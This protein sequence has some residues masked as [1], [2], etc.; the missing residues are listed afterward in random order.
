MSRKSFFFK[1]S[2]MKKIILLTVLLF[3]WFAH[4]QKDFSHYRLVYPIGEDPN[5]RWISSYRPEEK[6]LFEANPNVR[7]SFYNNIIKRFINEVQ[8]AEGNPLKG[9]LKHPQAYYIAV[10]PQFRMYNDNS[11]PVKMPSYRV[12]FGTQHL[13]NIESSE[14]RKKYVGFS[15]ES[16]HYSNGQSGCSFCGDFDDATAECDSVYNTITDDTNLSAL[17]N[18]KNGNYSTNMT[19]LI[20]NYRTY[21]L[22][23]VEFKPKSMHSFNLGVTLYHNLFFGLFDFGGYTQEDIEIY[24]H[25]RF[26][27]SYEYMRVMTKKGARLTF[28]DN[29]EII[30]GAHAQVQPLR[31][32]VMLTYYPF[33]NIKEFGFFTSYIYGHDNYNFRFVDSG[34]QFSVGMSWSQFP[35][36]PGTSKLH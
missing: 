24:G 25:W 30:E 22:D 32:E 14:Q 2:D 20:L 6:I 16:G 33:P 31:N 15:L 1:R 13:F 4:A 12:L 26:M 17:L 5:I 23:Q 28:K 8:D 36:F 27:P 7:F 21:R 3:A 10:R 18:R 11:K 29:I 9:F 34:H 19:E 35:D